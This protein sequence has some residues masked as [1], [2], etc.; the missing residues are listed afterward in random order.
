MIQE[1]EKQALNF[2]VLQNPPQGEMTAQRG[3]A[4]AF[5]WSWNELDER[6]RHLG[7]LLS[8]FAL[9][10]IP[11]NL[12]EKCLSKDESWEKGII[13]RWFPTFSR[14]WLLLMSPKKVDV[15]DSRTW[16]D[17]REDTLLDLNLIQKTTQGTYELH[18]LVRRYFQD[19]LNA[20]KEV[21]QLKSQ[22]C[23]VIVGAAR[24]IP[25]N[26]TVE[27]V[28][29]VEIDI[30]HIT[31]IADN[32]AEY[33]SDDDLITPFTRLGSFYQGQGLY[34]LAQPWLEKGK[35]IA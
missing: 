34:P 5:E 9:A 22:F 25:D 3:V 14:L 11:W 33:L 4:A 2:S 13:Q 31:E 19:K 16:E 1:L 15:L 12:V 27:Q 26:I 7:C 30:P 32:L 35:E 17:I 8:L 21:E 18:Q 28:K 20:M 6:G 24:K 29:E 23:R 10:P